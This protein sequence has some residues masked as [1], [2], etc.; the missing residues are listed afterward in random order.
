MRIVGVVA[1]YNPFHN[2]HAWHLQQAR[3]A[4]KADWVV[5]VMSSC[6]TQR[7]TA[8]CLSPR[9]RA[10]MALSAGADAVIAL[11]AFWA[12]RDAEHFALGGVS[13][14]QQMGVDAISFGAEA[15]VLP[16]LRDAAGLLEHAGADFDTAVQHHLDEGLSYP[17]AIAEAAEE[18]M[19]GMR[20]LL[21]SPNNTL[22]VSYLRAMMRLQAEMDVF[23][24]M[25]QGDYH[26]TAL[27]VGFPS[28][29]ALRG[30]M[31]RGD[32][33][34]LAQGIPAESLPILQKAALDGQMQPDNALDQAL[35]YR[36]RSMTK[37]DWRALPGLSEGIEDRLMTAARRTATREDLLMHAKTRRYPYARLSRLCTHALLNMTQDKLDHEPLPDAAWL[38][39]FHREARP[40]LTHISQ[41]TTLISKAA[42]VLHPSE[43]FRTEC[44]AYDLWA[45]GCGLPSGLAMTQGVARV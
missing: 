44:L 12:V 15:A 5:A 22:G 33:T 10:E 8:A 25:R 21:S 39:G 40:L 26:A 17:A 2:G 43:W 45:L 16:L 24:I 1:E 34:A 6:F 41:H 36:L 18:R 7:G 4:A 14:L 9:R 13:L 29:T 27:G 20:W 31:Q 11:P 37:A 42:D 19:H 32:W 23:P 28:A 30:C 3:E 35:L 38:L